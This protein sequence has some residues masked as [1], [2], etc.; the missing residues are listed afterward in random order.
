[1]NPQKHAKRVVP[2]AFREKLEELLNDPAV[3]ASLH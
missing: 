2:I 3:E 1:M